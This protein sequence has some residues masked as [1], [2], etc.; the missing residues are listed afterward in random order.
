MRSFRFVRET[1][2]SDRLYSSLPPVIKKMCRISEC[3]RG[4]GHVIEV[5]RC[6]ALVSVIGV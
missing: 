5:L 2:L 3:Y 4:V 6:V 1:I